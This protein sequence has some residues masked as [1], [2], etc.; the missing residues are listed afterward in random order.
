MFFF[1]DFK[2]SINN[3][4]GENRQTKKR[5]IDDDEEVSIAGCSR[6][7]KRHIEELKSELTEEKEKSR[8]LKEEK[9]TALRLGKVIKDN[10]LAI[11]SLA[12]TV[13]SKLEQE[14]V[15]SK[16]RIEELESQLSEEKEKSR[17]LEEKLKA[18][19]SWFCHRSSLSFV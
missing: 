14:R 5:K 12:E 18:S 13:M 8:K 4:D 2:S 10:M 6:D 17:K 3:E 19:C 11:G 16:R 15:T 9:D 7:Y 1:K